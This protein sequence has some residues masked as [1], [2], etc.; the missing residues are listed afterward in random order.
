MTLWHGPYETPLDSRVMRQAEIIDV[1]RGD[2]RSPMFKRLMSLCIP[3]PNFGVVS[4]QL[5][6]LGDSWSLFPAAGI[7]YLPTLG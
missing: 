2:P 4:T 6:N 7:G 5:G 1:S 3:C